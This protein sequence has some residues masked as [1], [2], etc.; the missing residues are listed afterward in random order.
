MSTLC[1][2][3]NIFISSLSLAL[4][5]LRVKDYKKYIAGY[6]FGF[7]PNVGTKLLNNMRSFD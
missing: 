5:D 4:Y 1:H 3:D 6:L 2:I 7:K